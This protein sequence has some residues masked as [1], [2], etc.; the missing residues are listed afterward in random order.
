M[1]ND[2]MFSKKSDLWRTPQSLFDLQNAVH[3]PFTLDF[4]ASDDRLCKAYFGPGSGEAEDALTVPF[5][6]LLGES[7]WCNPPYSQCYQFVERLATA[8]GSQPGRL[9]A[10]MLL[11]ARTDTKWWHNFIWNAWAPYP[12]VSVRFLKGRVKF[13]LDDQPSNSAPFP[14]V[15]VVFG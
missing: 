5:E 6:D 4:A 1:N 8:C 12:G 7:I 10:V 2:L 9:K 14:S 13:E 15:I 3:G 11:P